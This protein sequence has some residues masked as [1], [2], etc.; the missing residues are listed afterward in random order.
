[1]QISQCFYN[2]RFLT[3]ILMDNNTSHNVN[4]VEYVYSDPHRLPRAAS[5]IKLPLLSQ[6][7]KNQNSLGVI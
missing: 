1:M 3:C 5:L 7:Y 4:Y 2:M 6:S